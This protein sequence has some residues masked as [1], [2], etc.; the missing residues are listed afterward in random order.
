MLGQ[1]A[2]GKKTQFMIG[3][4][5]VVSILLALVFVRFLARTPQK[6]PSRSE[7]WMYEL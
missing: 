3:S 7:S 2:Q 1:Q 5:M 4:F 6:R